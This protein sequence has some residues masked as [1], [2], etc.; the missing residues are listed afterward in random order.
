MKPKKNQPHPVRIEFNHEQAQAVFIAGTFN[1]W[2]PNTTPMIA[3]GKGRW[4]KELALPPGRYE[5]QL[6]VDGIW[7]CDPSAPE[8][9]PNPY[10]G[11]NS[12]LIVV[13]GQNRTER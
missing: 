4:G 6:V 2:N 7:T 3:L 8:Q 1:D 10:G 11:H 9:V 12:V 5:Y 13:S